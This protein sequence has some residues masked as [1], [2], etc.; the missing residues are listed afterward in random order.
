MLYLIR[1]C[2]THDNDSNV[3]CSDKDIGLSMKG[4]KQAK[5]LSDWFLGKKIDI[6]L[7]SN[8]IRSIQTAKFISRVTNAPIRAF[9]E[10]QDRKVNEVYSNLRLSELQEVRQT[11]NQIFSDPTQ[12]WNGVENVESD[13]LIFL[14]IKKILNSQITHNSNIVCVTHAGAIKAFLHCV[15]NL[16]SERSNAFKVR[17]GC[18]LVFQNETD[19]SEIQL[20]GM[21]QI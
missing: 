10:L 17:N 3:L 12:D 8:L 16:N 15:F 1:H 2:S 21:Y 11:R 4:L 13:E 19:F 9:S 18:I 6:I 7:T 20:L 5:R 14:R